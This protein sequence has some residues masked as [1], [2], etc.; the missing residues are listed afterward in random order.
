VEARCPLLDQVVSEFAVPLP[1]STKLGRHEGKILL[2]RALRELLPPAVLS[3][4]K[5]GFGSPVANW[6][7]GPLR[8]LVGDLLLTPRISSWMD[9]RWVRRVAE[10]ALERRGNAHQAW[11]LLAL[12]AWARRHSDLE[13]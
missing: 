10:D 7:A 8:E 11:A 4:P 2:K 13:P 9:E 1:L 5:R 6:L 12:E 3:R